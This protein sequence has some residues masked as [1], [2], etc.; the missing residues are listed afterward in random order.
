MIS[1]QEQIVDCQI[2]G[3]ELKDFMILNP[4]RFNTNYLAHN[5]NL[6][7]FTFDSGIHLL[8]KLIYPTLNQ[9][10]D[11]NGEQAKPDSSIIFENAKRT[12]SVWQ[13]TD[14]DKCWKASKILGATELAKIKKYDI[15]IIQSAKIAVLY[16]ID[17]DRYEKAAKAC[18]NSMKIIQLQD[19][20]DINSTIKP[21]PNDIIIFSSDTFRE[22]NFAVS[23]GLSWEKSVLQICNEIFHNH[24]CKK[25]REYNY[26]LITFGSDGCLLISKRREKNSS[27]S[28]EIQFPYAHLGIF[29][30]DLLYDCYIVFDKDRSEFDYTS[31]DASVFGYLIVFQAAITL[32][33]LKAPNF[34]DIDKEDYD[35][36]EALIKGVLSGLNAMRKLC[37]IGYTKKKNSL[38]F[39]IEEIKKTID[40][41]LQNYI[42]RNDKDPNIKYREQ[43]NLY[44]YSQSRPI[45][46]AMLTSNIRNHSFSILDH[47]DNYTKIAKSI[48]TCGFDT[49]HIGMG[50]Y[51]NIPCCKFG[52]LITIDKNEIEKFRAIMIQLRCYIDSNIAR[53]LSIAVFGQPGTGKSFGIKEIVSH[54]K[55]EGKRKI[56]TL[57]F[58][59]SQMNTIEDLLNALQLVRDEGLKGN[60]PLVF[61]DEFDTVKDKQILGWIKYFLSPMEDG[62]FQGGQIMHPIGRAIFIFAGSCSHSLDEFKNKIESLDTSNLTDNA[63]SKG[64]DFISRLKGH[65]DIIGPNPHKNNFDSTYGIRR[66]ILIHS[67]M[68]N[69]FPEYTNAKGIINIDEYVLD[70]LLTTKYYYHGAR[71][72]ASI[73][74]MS[75]PTNK[76]RYNYS[77]LP[78]KDQLNL[79]VDSDD[80]YKRIAVSKYRKQ[81]LANSANGDIGYAK[82]GYGYIGSKMH[83]EF[84]RTID[85]FDIILDTDLIIVNSNG[86]LEY[87]PDFK[88][89]ED[90]FEEIIESQKSKYQIEWQRVLKNHLNRFN[91]Y[92]IRQI[93]WNINDCISEECIKLISSLCFFDDES[94]MASKEYQLFEKKYIHYNSAMGNSKIS[95]VLRKSDKKRLNS[96]IIETIASLCKADIASI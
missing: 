42:V 75:T 53:P 16:V 55:S 39:P 86:K 62:S 63:D 23:R 80:F 4:S 90:P 27:E 47:E 48:A 10:K 92:I 51:I 57:V 25:I 70:A 14:G 35:V 21:K 64:K 96:I 88:C 79:H 89:C 15:N 83:E 82:T 46:L 45:N 1:K 18:S 50:G 61:W 54:L 6:I 67:I 22:K 31:A 73:I 69:R 3:D 81:Q 76:E 66:A 85:I 84:I 44:N 40:L 19:I 94:E 74:N 7:D 43:K 2:H 32:S 29:K 30:D 52:K 24:R 65:V 9:K 12:Y 95:H 8:S 17:A 58:N 72:I 37:D 68:I 60:V 34:N 93:E 77:C 78:T 36:K 71:S 38:L 33:L 26:I 59:L 41:G 49:K 11:K 5:L 87:S 20:P 28:N 56:E 91:R 13:P